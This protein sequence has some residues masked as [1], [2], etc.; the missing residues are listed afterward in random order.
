MKTKK[1]VNRTC[2][3]CGIRLPQPQMIR[4]EV[5]VETGKSNAT[6]TG[7]TF[8]GSAFGDKS[9]QRAIIRSGFNTGQRT[10]TRKQTKWFC[11][12]CARPGIYALIKILSIPSR[13]FKILV[14]LFKYAKDKI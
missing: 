12:E 7:A 6:V 5:L 4:K 13:I 2:C 14:R 3:G 10:Y 1:Y 8:L 9:A 11:Y